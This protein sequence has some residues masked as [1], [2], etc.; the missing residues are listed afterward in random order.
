MPRTR[1]T[2]L[3]IRTAASKTTKQPA[4]GR[5]ADDGDRASRH[6]NHDR[7]GRAGWIDGREERFG[8]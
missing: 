3:K 4:H 5:A 1:K 2:T 7:A 8:R 6:E